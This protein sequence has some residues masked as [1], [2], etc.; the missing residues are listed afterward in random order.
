MDA[1][2]WN[3]LEVAKLVAGLFTPMA[4][5]IFGIYIH[6]VTKRF[7]LIQ[8]R[9]QKLIEK[10]IAIYDDLAPLLNDVLCYFN[11]VGHWKDV[12]PHAMIALKRTLDK[13]IHLAAPMFSKAFFSACID[14]QNLC[15]E[16]HTG[17]G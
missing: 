14:F 8:W 10:R 2:P 7:E 5:A 1:G 4:L 3:W 6:R 15:Y 12:D 9:S 16:T 13:K 17:W 11:Y